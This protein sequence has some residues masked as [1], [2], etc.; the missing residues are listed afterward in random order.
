MKPPAS[1]DKCIGQLAYLWMVPALLAL[2]EKINC[3]H[4]MRQLSLS[5]GYHQAS[6]KIRSEYV[7]AVKI[8]AWRRSIVVFIRLS[9]RSPRQGK[10]MKRCPSSSLLTLIG[11]S[12]RPILGSHPWLAELL[13]A[14]KP[15]IMIFSKTR[16]FPKAK[17][18]SS[19]VKEREIMGLLA[20][21]KLPKQTWLPLARYLV[22]AT[23]SW[24]PSVIV[25]ITIKLLHHWT[26]CSS[27]VSWPNSNVSSKAIRETRRHSKWKVRLR[28]NSTLGKEGRL[29]SLS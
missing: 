13:L 17:S 8:R 10:L 18:F 25:V 6:L 7:K 20:V 14:L 3:A 29:A 4:P 24:W 15:T 22:G 1:Q 11:S 26:S 5:L 28:E 19:L 12:F 27:R 21:V 16:G 2:A 23:K 9:L